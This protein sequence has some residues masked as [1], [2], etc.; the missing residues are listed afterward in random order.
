MIVVQGI[1]MAG[2]VILP[3]IIFPFVAGE[4]YR[5]INT[6]NFGRDEKWYLSQ[7]REILEGHGLGNPILREGKAGPDMHFTFITEA[8]VAP[9][10]L[11]GLTDEQIDIVVLYRVFTFLGVILLSTLVYGLVLFLSEDKVLAVTS[12]AFVVGGYPILFYQSLFHPEFIFYGRAFSPYLGSIFFF[13]FANFLV[14]AL[15]RDDVKMV[16]FSAASFGALFYVYMFAWTFAGALLAS[17]CVLYLIR[18]EY[19]NVRKIIIIGFGGLMLGA[20]NLIRMF[21]FYYAEAGRQLAYFGWSVGTHAALFNKI[22]FLATIV[23]VAAYII[24]KEHRERLSPFLAFVIAGW[25]ALNQQVI[26]GRM[27]QPT[28]Y[29]WFFVTP[30]AIIVSLYVLWLTLSRFKFRSAV[31]IA[32]VAVV[33]VSALVGEARATFVSMPGKMYEQRYKPIL[34]YLNKDAA[35]DVVFTA[36][37]DNAY[38]ITVYTPQDLFWNSTGAFIASTSIE[39]IKD[40]V[41]VYAYLN[42]KSRDNFINYFEEMMSNPQSDFV[43]K[44]TYQG[45]EGYYS[46]H[47]FF[48]YNRLSGM[49]APSILALR[50]DILAELFGEYQQ[51]SQSP[52]GIYSLFNKYGINYI[53]WDK[54]L[55]KEWGSSFI[56]R[57]KPVLNS[58]NIFLYKI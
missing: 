45:L 23:V 8:L 35:G 19:K 40:A 31:F 1:F 29:H 36:D 7:G 41:L 13:I 49:N 50:R 51:L 53:I 10:A 15:R 32:I 44:A 56:S 46:G 30:L 3:M 26:T 52:D 2:V 21:D 58:N 25:V 55:N 24:K 6:A 11:A 38:L 20:P 9:L 33:N 17:F 12:A 42:G 18:H 39:R 5:S 22:N 16:I 34:D 54:T 28:H 48:E 47:D 57:L 43:A 14:R 37:E 4:N 27:L